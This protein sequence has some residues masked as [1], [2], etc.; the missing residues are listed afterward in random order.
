MIT[1]DKYV[2]FWGDQDI[3]SNFYP[4]EFEISGH[5]FYW[6]EQAFMWLKA[7]WFADHDL[8]QTLLLL[9]PPNNKPIHAK[10]IGRTIKGFNEEEWAKV[11]EECMFRACLAKFQ[12]N[13]KLSEQLLN[14]GDRVLVEASPYDKIWGIG[15]AED[16]ADAQDPDKWQGLNLLGKVLMNVRHELKM[17][18]LAEEVKKDFQ[19]AVD[20]AE[21]ISINQ[22]C[23]DEAYHKAISK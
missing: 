21:E 9:A 14:T 7:L 15:L 20:E 19:E 17:K 18:L 16:N 2:L 12:Q 10:K 22:E 3:Y 8:A 5:H 13:V 6:S 11:R 1:T 23:Y 4:V